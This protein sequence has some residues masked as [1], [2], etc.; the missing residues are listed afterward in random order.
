MK[1]FLRQQF[2][3][4]H[5]LCFAAF[6]CI[7][8]ID[9]SSAPLLAQSTWYVRSTGV[10][11]SESADGKTWA[12]AFPLL[13]SALQ[14]ARAGDAV[15]IARGVYKP[16]VDNDRNKRFELSSGVK[17]Y[18]G[19]LGIETEL[20]QRN[21]TIN[22]T[23]LSGDIGVPN[24]STD[25]AYTIL[26]VA[27]T[28]RDTRI[29]GL[30]V[31]RGIAN[32]PNDLEVYSHLPSQSGGGLYMTAQDEGQSA[33][34]TVENCIF[35]RNWA[36]HMGGAIY[37]NLRDGGKGTIQLK[38]TV[39]QRNRS[40]SRGGA[41]LIESYQRTGIPTAIEGCTFEENMCRFG[42]GAVHFIHQEDVSIKGTTF[43]KNNAQF[44]GAGASLNFEGP[45]RNRKIDIDQCQ[46][47]DYPDQDFDASV[48]YIFDGASAENGPNLNI[49]NSRFW[50]H[51]GGNLILGFYK[52]MMV[53]CVLAENEATVNHSLFGGSGRMSLLN[54]TL[55]DN[56]GALRFPDL[57]LSLTNC[58]WAGR[59]R[60]TT[61][62]PTDKKIR[63][64]NCLTNLATCEALDPNAVCSNVLFSAD[65]MFVNPVQGDFRLKN[66]SPAINAGLTRPIDSLRVF[67]D[68]AGA[69]RRSGGLVDLGA[70]EYQ[71]SVQVTNIKQVSCG[72]GIDGAVSFTHNLCEPVR[73]AWRSSTGTTGT[74]PNNLAAA[75]YAF[76]LTDARGSRETVSDVQIKQPTPL[77]HTFKIQQPTVGMTNGSIQTD[78]KGGFPPYKWAWNSGQTTT[79]ISNIGSGNY[80]VTV[81]DAT[82]CTLT[83]YFQLR[84]IVS[85]N[86]AEGTSKS[87]RL[88]PNPVA[89]G[90]FFS[91]GNDDVVV[92]EMA[93]FDALGRLVSR[94]TAPGAQLPAPASPG[95]YGV[96]VRLAHEKKGRML[97]LQVRGD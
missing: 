91:V 13:Q 63:L 36:D 46:F 5:L 50:R 58:I 69:Q 81:T 23:I 51:V 27:Q 52:G 10:A 20:R 90:Q 76:T 16:T 72:W 24:D 37:L 75:T 9:V 54:C 28:N 71:P 56:S 14:V 26:Y 2:G 47:L 93:I 88:T 59:G 6:I 95:M 22:P 11:Q 84:G 29:D 17:L 85:A 60:S 89:A 83:V 65:P 68:G 73:Y 3:G 74:E 4:C 15:W 35:R 19:F 62:L 40:G 67:T 21:W 41:L 38:N 55:I 87:L 78:V 70:F 77:S 57:E 12:T 53:N 1:T 42:G 18:G 64:T 44:A 31:E 7:F 97:L 39:F 8:L 96:M 30:I 86:E 34:L 94:S 43:R 25:N 82:N 92:A 49:R 66:C 79:N 80:L 61:Q 32:N 33:Y 48:I 45:V